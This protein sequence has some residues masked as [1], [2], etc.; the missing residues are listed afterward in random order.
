MFVSFSVSAKE[1]DRYTDFSGQAKRFIKANEKPLT[2]SFKSFTAKY[3]NSN[4]E[5]DCYEYKEATKLFLV[6]LNNDGKLEGLLAHTTEGC[7]GGNNAARMITVF[8][9]KNDKWAEAGDIFIGSLILGFGKVVEIQKNR[10][11]TKS[12]SSKNSDLDQEYLLKG[13]KL[14]P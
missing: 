8:V 6:D 9:N 1:T 14:E 11:R 7:G 3:L 2:P 10:I 4:R 5:G 13:D 12:D